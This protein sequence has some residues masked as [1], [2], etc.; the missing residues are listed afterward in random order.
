MLKLLNGQKVSADRPLASSGRKITLPAFPTCICR[1]LSQLRRL[2]TNQ[3][4]T[5]L[6]IRLTQNATAN[7]DAIKQRLFLDQGLNQR[8]LLLASQFLGCEG[9][10]WGELLIPQ[11]LALVVDGN[12]EDWA[13][14]EPVLSDKSGDS[15]AGETMDIRALSMKMDDNYLYLLLEAGPRPAGRWGLDFFMDFKAPN[16]CGSSERSIK[17]W[18]D[19]PGAFTV[20]SVDGCPDSKP[21]TYPALFAWAEALRC[22]FL[23][24]PQ[25]SIGGAGDI[26]LKAFCGRAGRFSYPDYMR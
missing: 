10:P 12:R 26:E 13:N 23:G 1:F 20:G 15:T 9:Y 3:M 5:R 8:L 19:E 4:I 22:A 24:V 17:V 18:S 7:V 21:Q 2:P 14:D 25:Q 6:C 16:A 11:Q